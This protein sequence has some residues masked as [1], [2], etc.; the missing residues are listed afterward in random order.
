MKQDAKEVAVS[1]PQAVWIACNDEEMSKDKLFNV[2]IPQAV[3]IACNKVMEEDGTLPYIV[4][5]PQAVWIACNSSRRSMYGKNQRVSIPQAVWI[6]CN[7][8]K[9]ASRRTGLWS[10]NTASGIDCMQW[11]YLKGV[12]L[13]NEVSTPHTVWIA[14]NTVPHSPWDS[15]TQKRVF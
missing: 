12:L 11:G 2:S 1:I 15:W 3:L 9:P 5:I 4:S 7:N 14:C 10:F 13:M 6:A 8:W